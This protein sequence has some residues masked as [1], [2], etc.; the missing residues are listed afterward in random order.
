VVRFS[1]FLTPAAC[2]DLADKPD[3]SALAALAALEIENHGN[4]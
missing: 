2:H 4:F 1:R 3:L